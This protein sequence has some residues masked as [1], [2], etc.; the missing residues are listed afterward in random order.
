MSTQSTKST[1][2][3][4]ERYLSL[5]TWRKSGKEVRTPVWFAQDLSDPKKLW[6][7]T[8]R[9]SGKVKRVTSA[10]VM[11]RFQAATRKVVEDRKKA[12]AKEKKENEKKK[13]TKKID[14]GDY[15]TEKDHKAKKSPRY[16]P[17]RRR[18]GRA[19]RAAATIASRRRSRSAP[20]RRRS[21]WTRRTEPHAARIR[22][23]GRRAGPRCGP[24]CSGT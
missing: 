7:Y 2:S 4:R 10:S 17:I 8:N 11:A 9:N 21:G 1:L 6:I 16:S 23:G 12:A 15:V 19:S 5:A 18:S 3:D 14:L 20:G 22:R 24:A 13:S